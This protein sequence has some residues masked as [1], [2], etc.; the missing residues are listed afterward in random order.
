MK[1]IM[2]CMLTIWL[3]PFAVLAEDTYT[4]KSVEFIG[5]SGFLK[6]PNSPAEINQRFS[7]QQT[8]KSIED[9][10]KSLNEALIDQGFYLAILRAEY[11]RIDEGVLVL[12]VDQGRVGKINYYRLPGGF[13]GTDVQTRKA[14]RQPYQG[15][16]EIEQ[17]NHGFQHQLNRAFNY[18]D[19]HLEIFRLNSLPDLSLDTDIRVREE[20]DEKGI[21]RRYVDL[22]FYVND[23]LPVHGVFE[24]KNTGTHNTGGHRMDFT[25]QHLNLTKRND[26]L[27]M[28]LLSSLDLETLRAFSTSYNRPI[29]KGGISLTGGYSDLNVDEIVSSIDLAAEGWFI[30]NRNFHNLVDNS[31]H[32]LNV[33]YGIQLSQLSDS[34]ILSEGEQVKTDIRTVPAS[35]GMVYHS[36]EPDAW[37]G[38]NFI[39]ALLTQNMG[40]ALGVTKD[41]EVRAIREDADADYN[42]VQVQ[43]SRIQSL[44]GRVDDAS[45][46]Q[47][48]AHYLLASVDA[49]Y[50]GEPLVSAEKK[51]VGG[52]ESVRGYPENFVAGDN[53][54]SGKLELRTLIFKGLLTKWLGRKTNFDER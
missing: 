7:G 4:V 33:A 27:S 25:L 23:R 28:V 17:L 44:G 35:L 2:Y 24:I 18:K 52:M 19:L 37:G 21:P 12:T 47:V 11:D 36:N 13:S 14:N 51:A 49:Q 54:I 40:D 53:G 5:D 26:T 15:Y 22:D 20:V 45:G 38:R 1:N 43:G 46:E 29:D 31:S 30:G 16:F 32:T 9:Q 41:E 10:V 6:S 50:A 34:L 3:I 42:F 48:Y 39:T 8:E